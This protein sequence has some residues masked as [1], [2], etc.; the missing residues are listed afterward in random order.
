MHLAH[1]QDEQADINDHL[2]RAKSLCSEERKRER[3]RKR[4]EKLIA[5]AM[6][7]MNRE[8][9]YSKESKEEGN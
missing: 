7:Y 1:H 5:V 9:N 2:L 3:K 4:Q 6:C 8:R